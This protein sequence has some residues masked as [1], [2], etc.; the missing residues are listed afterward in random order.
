M[1]RYTGNIHFKEN[2]KGFIFMKP[3]VLVAP[4]TGLEP[5]TL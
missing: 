3:F 4:S 2:K 5:V 1:F